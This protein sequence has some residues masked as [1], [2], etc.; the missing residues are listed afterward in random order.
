MF[1]YSYS[2]VVAVYLATDDA[3]AHQVAQ[4]ILDRLALE[5]D[6]AR[7]LRHSMIRMS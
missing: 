1:S 4:E 2:D 7:L 6:G 3:A 5:A